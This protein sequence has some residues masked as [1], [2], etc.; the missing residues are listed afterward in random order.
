MAYCLIAT[1]SP[2]CG[3]ILAEYY[4]R[5]DSERKAGITLALLSLPGNF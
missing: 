4:D 1:T 2:D 5:E 3:E